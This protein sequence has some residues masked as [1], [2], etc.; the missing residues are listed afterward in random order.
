M[1]EY[2]CGFLLSP[3]RTQ[4][5]LVLK[6]K[7]SWQAGRLN[8]VGG[9][10]EPGETPLQAMVR[11]YREEAG[12]DAPEECWRHRVTL[13]G[14]GRRVF[15]FLGQSSEV[16][17]SRTTHQEV[18]PVRA[19]QLS[20][21]P[22]LSVMPNLRWLIPLCMDKDIAG[23]VELTDNSEPATDGAAVSERAG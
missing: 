22:F 5:S 4:V 10:I 19:Y 1:V 12:I 23:A 17:L 16:V 3:D 7:P 13:S 15:F 11:E 8:G 20:Q 6:A 18:E 9:K 2:V 21:M 14:N